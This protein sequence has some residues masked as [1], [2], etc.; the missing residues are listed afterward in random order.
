MEFYRRI[1]LREMFADANEHALSNLL[2]ETPEVVGEWIGE[3]LTLEG[4]EQPLLDV[5]ADILFRTEDGKRVEVEV[6]LGDADDQHLGE[7]MRHLTQ[8]EAMFFVWVAQ[9]FNREMCRVVREW[10][11]VNPERAFYAVQVHGVSGSHLL[12]YEVKEQPFTLD[13]EILDGR[14]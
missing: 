5:R 2:A 12:G 9:S 7:I 6:Q 13:R 11:R 1:N 4:R 8:I 3:N 14:I 10:N